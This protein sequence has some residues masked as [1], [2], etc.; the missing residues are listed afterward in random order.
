M[1]DIPN[2]PRMLPCGDRNGISTK[3]A[4]AYLLSQIGRTR[5]HPGRPLIA[6]LSAT[7]FCQHYLIYAKQNLL[8]FAIL[9]WMEKALPTHSSITHTKISPAKT[10]TDPHRKRNQNTNVK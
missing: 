9:G 5:L 1:E 7:I 2:T 3:E 10:L 6:P 8:T 4:Y